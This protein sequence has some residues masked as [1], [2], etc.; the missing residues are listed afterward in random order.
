MNFLKNLRVRSKLL[1]LISISILIA[2][3]I[4]GL[5]FIQSIKMANNMETIYEEKFIPN[6][7]LNNAVS[8]NLRIDST[9]IQMMT[10]TDQQEKQALHNEIYDG[11]DQ[12]LSDF[13]QYS[14]MNLTD[15]ERQGVV[16]YYDAVD[17][18]TVHQDKV[19]ELALAGQNEEA[20]KMYHERVKQPRED[21]ISTLHMLSQI[22]VGQTEQIVLNSITS[23][24][25]SNLRNVIINIGAIIILL[26]LGVLISLMITKPI[27]QLRVQLRKV[28]NGDFTVHGDYQSK[29]EIGALTQ[30]FNETISSLNNDLQKVKSSSDHVENTSQELMA[31]VEQSTAAAEH[32]VS[33]IQEISSGAEETKYRLEQNAIIIERVA[34]GFTTIQQDFQAIDR[35]AQKS[36]AES[37]EGSVIVSKNV[38]Q[39]KNIKLSVQQSNEVVQTLANQVGEV[40]EILKVIDWIS[41]QTNLLALN[42]AIEAA[43]AGEHG[44]GF[45]VVADEVRKLAEQSIQATKSVATILENIKKDTDESVQIMN[46]VIDEAESGLTITEKTAQKFQEILQNTLEVG[47]VMQKTTSS[48]N[49]IVK[50]FSIFTSSADTI[51]TISMNNSKNS[52]MVSAASE[53]QAAA[54]EDMSQSSHNLTNVATELNGIVKKFTL[55]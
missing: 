34:N 39:M 1:L 33:S 49:H 46:V 26:V 51:L 17:R 2:I 7:W 28:Q 48:V 42:A 23:S 32:V 37:K 21:L 8:V 22:K 19:I 4:A 44:K 55:Q 30:S 50:D 24:D 47:P 52:A 3:V 38:E 14:E 35:L 10:T 15:E 40:D 16:D 31:N 27:E 18:L 43:R 36:I 45:A 29:D 54:M 20:Y 12:V 41:G 9:I 5:S 25:E 13:A 11:I 6:S 53:Q